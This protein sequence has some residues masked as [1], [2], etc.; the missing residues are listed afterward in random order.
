MS[1]TR[2]DVGNPASK[3]IPMGRPAESSRRYRLAS[4]EQ[5]K[6]ARVLAGLSR[7]QLAT[8]IGRSLRTITGWESSIGVAPHASR[9]SLERLEGVLRRYGVALYVTPAGGYGVEK[10][11]RSAG[12]D[13]T[14]DC[15][16][17]QCA[18]VK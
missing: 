18:T 2:E 8:E 10:A 1:E 4:A 7:K 16:S 11:A 17:G 5:L 3:S 15:K 13:A 12:K 9:T 6:A 14:H